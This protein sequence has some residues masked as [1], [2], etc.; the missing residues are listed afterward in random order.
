MRRTTIFR[1]KLLPALAALVLVQGVVRA[2]DS[3]QV[4]PGST[5]VVQTGE[6]LWGLAGQYLGDAL[7]W[8]AIYRLNTLVVEDPHWIFPGEELQMV[9]PDSTLVGPGQ[10]VVAQAP[11][12]SGQVPIVTPA[13]PADTFVAGG[14][15]VAAQP[16]AAASQGVER[17]VAPTVAGGD[18]PPPPPPPGEGAPTVFTARA[19]GAGAG[20]GGAV[21]SRN[22]RPLSSSDFFGAGFLTENDQFPWASVKGTVGKERLGSLTSLSSAHIFESIEIQAP[23]AATYQVGDSLIVATLGREVPKWGRVVLPAG[24]VRVRESTGRFVVADV[25]VQFGRVVSGQVAMPVES[26]RSPGRVFPTPIDNGMTGTIIDARDSH[27]LP[28]DMSIVFI[29]RGREDGLTPGDVFEVLRPNPVESSPE[30]PLQQVAVMQVVHVRQRSASA[31]I[32]QIF[33]VGVKAGAPV[34]LIRKMPS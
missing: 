14:V 11:A 20:V 12:P 19:R 26:F 4:V 3:A 31:Q 28:G 7:L 8:P 25:L 6:T 34:R 22:L 23:E 27:P 15:A 30:T 32:L 1:S 18:L 10:Q 16:L 33:G 17:P 21:H 24:I 29:D 9:T 13:A 2:Q 5:H